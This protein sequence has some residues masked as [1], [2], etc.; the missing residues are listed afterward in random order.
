MSDPVIDGLLGGW[1]AGPGP[2]AQDQASS[3]RREFSVAGTTEPNIWRRPL[4]EDTRQAQAVLLKARKEQA[5]TLERLQFIPEEL[6][7][8]AAGQK[9]GQVSFG[10][11]E[12]LSEEQRRLQESLRWLDANA[13]RPVSFEAGQ[14]DPERAAWASGWEEFRGLMARAE[15]LVGY[16]AWVETSLGGQMIARTVVDWTAD[17]RT[18]WMEGVT[19]GQMEV[20]ENELSL[21][22][23]HRLTLI[24]AVTLT[25]Q[26]AARL[27]VT[28]TIPGGG[29]LAIPQVWQY[30]KKMIEL[31]NQ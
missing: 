15:R 16:L 5:A 28:L 11:P 9:P 21:A 17:S 14:V 20:H 22:L 26:S 18:E 12:L 4:P 7:H 24:Q 2:L 8:L 3:A 1:Q 19:P 6:G 31:V 25:A 10:A 30:V 27:S 13:R 23:G 29:L